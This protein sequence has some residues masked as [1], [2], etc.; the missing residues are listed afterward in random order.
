MKCLSVQ[1]QL[2]RSSKLEEDR[3]I[4]SFKEMCDKSSLIKH[5][6]IEKGYDEG[7]YININYTTD[8]LKALWGQ[9]RSHFYEQEDFGLVLAKASIVVCEGD[10][11]WDDYLLLHHFDEREEID[12]I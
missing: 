9:I 2:E 5:I 4:H 8:N 6:D 11:G 10:N 3:I 7:S 1:I 12:T